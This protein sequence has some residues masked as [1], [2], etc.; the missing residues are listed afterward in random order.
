MPLSL[1]NNRIRES[2]SGSHIGGNF[3][4]T[5]KNSLPPTAI[6]K[7]SSSIFKKD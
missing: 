2:N 1:A 7:S 5:N 4:G 6:G 3:K